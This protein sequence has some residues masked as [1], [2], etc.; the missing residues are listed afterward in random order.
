MASDK[1]TLIL[2]RGTH[3]VSAGDATRILDAIDNEDKTV[4]VDVEFT[5]MLGRVCRTTIV[6]S[7]VVGLV[8]K[9]QARAA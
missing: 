2:T 9:T 8:K 7:H 3:T 1:Y 5:E 4:E 6:V